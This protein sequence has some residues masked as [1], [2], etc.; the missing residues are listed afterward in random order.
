MCSS[1]LCKAG[2]D[3]VTVDLDAVAGY[4]LFGG[5][6]FEKQSVTAAEIKHPR[7]CFDPISDEA[8]LRPQVS[9][10]HRVTSTRAK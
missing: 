4:A 1:D 9:Y 8:V 6:C 7:T 10:A 5:K 3:I 2:N